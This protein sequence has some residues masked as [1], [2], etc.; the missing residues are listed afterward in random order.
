[1]TLLHHKYRRQYLLA[2]I[3]CCREGREFCPLVETNKQQEME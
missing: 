3:E 2:E 1:M